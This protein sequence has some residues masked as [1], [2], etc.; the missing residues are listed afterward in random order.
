VHHARWLKI[1]VVYTK[2]IRNLHIKMSYGK[3]L[4]RRRDFRIVP[5]IAAN[6]MAALSEIPI[7]RLWRYKK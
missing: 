1:S 5:A 2:H 4:A 3:S 7:P 6:Q